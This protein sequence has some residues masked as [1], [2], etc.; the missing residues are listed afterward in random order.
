MFFM[1]F[2][3][4]LD[5]LTWSPQDIPLLKAVTSFIILL[6]IHHVFLRYIKADISQDYALLNTR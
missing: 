5:L 3:I 1:H 2:I 4:L 6:G